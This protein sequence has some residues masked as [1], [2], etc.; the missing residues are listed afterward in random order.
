M[1]DASTD[2]LDQLFRQAEQALQKYWGYPQFRP[3][4]DEVVKSVFAGNDTLVLFPTGGGKS[5]CYQVP[6]LVLEGL[7]IVISPLVALM[8]D[9][10]EQL[11]S[12]NIRATYI[13][14]TITKSEIEQRLINARNGMYRLLYMAPERLATPLFQYEL[15]NLKPALIAID[16][17]HCI[18][19]WGH[20]FRPSYREIR[21][22]MEAVADRVKW[23]ALTAT[24]TPEVRDDI[25]KV[26]G[27]KTP[28]VISKGFDRPNLHWW[29]Y[30]GED[31]IHA[32]QRMF[33]RHQGS[34]LIYAGTR[35]SCNELSAQL[36]QVSGR[37]VKPYHAGLSPR[38]RSQVQEQWV[39]GKVPLVVATNAFGM[40]IDKP[41]CRYV[42]HYDAPASLEAYYQEAGRA[43]RDGE[44][45]Y[46][47]L[48][49]NPHTFTV[50]RQQIENSY[51]TR[52]QLLKIYNCVCDTLD[53]AVGS[54]MDRAEILDLKSVEQRSGFGTGK[55]MAAL[56]IFK[57]LELFDLSSEPGRQIGVQFSMDLGLI[58]QITQDTHYSERKRQF[59]Q[60]I[61]RLF[62]PGSLHE[63]VWLSAS[64]VAEK[65][66]F[67]FNRVVSG[68]EVLQ[69]EQL[70]TA[71]VLNGDPM[72]RIT[73]IR[74][75]KPHLDSVVVEQYREILLKKLQYMQAYCETSDCRSRFLRT[76]FGEV[77]P[78]RCGTCDNCVKRAKKSSAEGIKQDSETIRKI[79][80][81][82]RK[83]KKL[84]I[85]GLSEQTGIRPKA[86]RTGLNQLMREKLVRQNRTATGAYYELC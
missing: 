15:L 1:P 29:V 46:P 31:R 72:V 61:F 54:E 48:L 83:H 76:Y 5:L 22:N 50:M 23:L 84:H 12:R 2:T 18:S 38:Q 60:D 77:N 35:K 9:Q 65:T 19:E 69:R 3:G 39:S 53:L 14:S 49:Y 55:I 51:P 58:R 33:K 16:E 27:F 79:L 13:N 10:V 74:E 11:N 21:E 59:I 81:A 82:L 45:G 62:G 67:T 56:R 66:G 25:V 71:K 85:H 8:E 78:P 30:Y 17:A 63:I 4:Q 64:Y 73:T 7:T 42:I 86:L 68:L 70:L 40:G 6:A 34:G 36:Q 75:L 20:D 43:G 80:F 57:R 44:T 26:L 24:A 32:V 41:D 47:V 37:A 28:K 52:D